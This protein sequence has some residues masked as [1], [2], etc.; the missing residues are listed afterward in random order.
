[1]MQPA[2]QMD[3]AWSAN[4]PHQERNPDALREAHSLAA[5]LHHRIGFFP[6]WHLAR[7]KS[8]MLF[9][10]VEMHFPQPR[11]PA[12]IARALAGSDAIKEME[13]AALGAALAY[14]ARI[15][16]AGQ[17]CAVN[18][19][20]SSDT[21]CCAQS[22][23]QYVKALRAA[24]LSPACPLFI[25]IEQIPAGM[26]VSRLCD[27]AALV[28]SPAVRVLL[29][30]E[31]IRAIPHLNIGLKVAG[32]GA[33]LPER[34]PLA[35]A[36]QL[37]AILMSRAGEQRACSYLHGLER[38]ELVEMAAAAGLK[39][40]TGLGFGPLRGFTGLEELP[41]LPLSLDAHA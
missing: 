6:A 21:L 29:E 10:G 22:R 37:M 35:Q 40:G 11:G 9:L 23:V 28:A 26:P 3:V 17:I 8:Q 15:V 2:K 5:Q 4:R 7:R 19:G 41:S 31:Q 32:I 27:L 25:T 1:M 36:R 33:V 30:F 14:R 12:G 16:A 34:C 13:I 24:R 38:K 20:V 39:F 18:V